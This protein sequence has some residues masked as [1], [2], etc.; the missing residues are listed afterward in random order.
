[1]SDAV[2]TLF[3]AIHANNPEGVRLLVRAEPEL[4]QARS[5]SGLSPVMF[6][7]YYQRPYVLD[8]LLA[9]G[10]EL[11]V[12]E[13][14]ATGQP[15]PEGADVNAFNP[16]GFTPLHL[17]AMFGR[18]EAARALLGGGADLHALSRN[19][20]RPLP[21]TRRSAGD[22]GRRRGCCW[23]RAPTRTPRNPA[24]G[25]RCCWRCARARQT[26]WPSC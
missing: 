12:F 11:D 18:T 7:A 5:P 26:W 22:S 24:A 15:L 1:M 10:P 13:A 3:T 23:S 14:A 9:A 8:V 21:C 2:T 20:Q 19:P 16:D 25:P 4:L 17:A 6:A